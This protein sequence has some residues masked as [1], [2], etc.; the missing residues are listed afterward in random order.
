MA[1][2][3]FSEYGYTP[4]IATLSQ[5]KYN[6]TFDNDTLV[7]IGSV[8]FNTRSKQIVAFVQTDTLYLEATLEPD[9]VS[10]WLSPD[11]LADE[12]TSWSPYNYVMNNPII[13]IDPDGR[14][15]VFAKVFLMILKKLLQSLYNI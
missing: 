9:I 13:Y 11:P 10:R 7:Q 5:G 6:E 1:Q 12:Y 2:N 4:K 15:V 3:P 8:L 14:K